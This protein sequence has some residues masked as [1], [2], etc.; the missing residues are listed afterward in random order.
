MNSENKKKKTLA[1]NLIYN[2][3]GG[4][5]AQIKKL[6]QNIDEYEFSNFIFY[7][8]PKNL[9]LVKPYSR[10]NIKIRSSKFA[11]IN[12]ITRTIWEQFFLPFYLFFDKVNILFC[13]GNIAPIV[14]LNK[15]VQWIGTI[16]P[17]EKNFVRIYAQYSIIKRFILFFNKIL[18]LYSSKTSDH[19]FFES[20]YTRDLFIKRY[21]FNK[22]NTSV[23]QIGKDEFYRPEKRVNS[24]KY[25]DLLDK[26]FLL[27]VSHLYPYKNLETL[28]HSFGRLRK[29]HQDLI[30]ILAG[31]TQNLKYLRKLKDLVDSYDLD[32]S[33]LFLGNLEPNE[34]RQFYSQ[35]YSLIF[36]SPF[37]NFAYTLV[38]AMSCGAPIIST[39]STAMPET[40]KSSALYFEP[41]S[42]EDLVK[43]INLLLFDDKLRNQLI[44]KS[45][46][47]ANELET[48]EIINIKTNKV[49][50][51]IL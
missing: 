17:F 51:T 12:L 23:L 27:S 15:K 32:E 1:I 50:Q 43:K 40:C 7:I 45:L 41:Y 10:S 38:E 13:P 5:L 14:S 18:I 34:L 4:S 16:G 24:E 31:S 9:N 49:L 47:R 39:N 6:I 25:S 22:K 30:L 20:F 3:T 44:D 33:I 37:E 26:K 29:T 36:T 11:G 19:V 35:C 42:V 48:Y 8:T 2:P 28:I 21:N 46:A